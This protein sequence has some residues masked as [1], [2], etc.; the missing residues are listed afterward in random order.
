MNKNL[1]TFVPTLIA[2]LVLIIL[3]GY[4]FLFE[5]SK[6]KE[7]D[8]Q[9]AVF[10]GIEKPQIKSMTLKYPDREITL[11]KGGGKWHVMKDSTRFS[12]DDDEVGSLL[13]EI[14]KMEVQEV[15]A[16]KPSSLDEFGLSSPRVEVKF[17]IPHNEYR[18]IIGSETPVGS[19]TYVKTGADDK[20]LIVDKNSLLPFLDR[21]ENDFRDKQILALDEDRIHAVI[22]SSGSSSFEVD[23]KDGRWVGKDMPDY[24][25]LDQD[26]IRL[27]IKAF[28]NLKIDNFEA[29]NPMNL[30]AYGLDKP[31]AAIEIFED[32]NS[33]RVL[34][35]NKKENGDY[36]IKLDSELPVYSVSEYVFV[37]IPEN[38]NEIRVRK[39]VNID[40]TKVTGVEI[41]EGGKYL[42][43]SQIGDKWTVINNGNAQVSEK[44]IKDLLN[45]I[46][47]LEVESF[48]D[49]N[50]RD[51]A[52]Y[53]LDR[54]EIQIT[55]TGPGDEKVTLLFGREE[56]KKVY[57]KI[58][59]QDSIY[60]MSDVII[61]K[62]RVSEN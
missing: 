6:K 35:G 9:Q 23:R 51:L 1:R 36:Y 55:V 58:W 45:E 43:I 39:V 25:Q 60:K 44:R 20:V 41:K 21:S 4:L 11:T 7:T 48:V 61:S 8:T 59:G 46:G 13:S 5:M 15:A 27:I 42:S 19:G 2:A 32:D 26:R 29:D 49:D 40:P 31:N 28:L 30:A 24:V 17:K 34:F 53:G 47:N 14:S 54:P 16:D 18:L 10:P 62:I 3:L 22:F 37:Q 50:P 57:A 12:G 38:I 56:D 52:P 33:I